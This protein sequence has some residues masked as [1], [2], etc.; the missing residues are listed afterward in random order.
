MI[1][2]FNTFLN[3]VVAV[4]V[5]VLSWTMTLIQEKG[6]Q[7]FPLT[8]HLS[9]FQGKISRTPRSTPSFCATVGILR[10]II[11]M[12]KLGSW[13]RP[14]Q[15]P[16]FFGCPIGPPT[17][18]SLDFEESFGMLVLDQILLINRCIR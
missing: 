5:A 11:V 7:L 13:R 12:S 10:D 1:G 14:N 18:P 16:F 9:F 17:T 3:N 8:K 2:F 6:M 4:T 15:V